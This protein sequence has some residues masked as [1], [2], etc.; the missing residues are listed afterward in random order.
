M[1][2]SWANAVLGT[3]PQAQS[4]SE[5][6]LA[7]ASPLRNADPGRMEL[8]NQ[9]VTESLHAT[10]IRVAERRRRVQERIGDALRLRRGAKHGVRPAAVH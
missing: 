8:Y 5:S 9:L 4:V 10:R 7:A 1:D 3:S 2:G 6:L